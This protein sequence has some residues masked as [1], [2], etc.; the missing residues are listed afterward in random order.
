[1]S[2][3]LKPKVCTVLKYRQLLLVVSFQELFGKWSLSMFP[4]TIFF[5]CIYYTDSVISAIA[6]EKKKKQKSFGF[7]IMLLPEFG[8]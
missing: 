1:M 6:T 7:F 8:S 5:K 4:P 2:V 3:K